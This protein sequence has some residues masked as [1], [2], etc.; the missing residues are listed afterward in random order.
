M[1]K[2]IYFYTSDGLLKKEVELNETTISGIHGMLTRCTLNNGTQ[3]S[4]YAV[5]DEKE[6][7]LKLWNWKN[8]DEEKHILIGDNEEKFEQIFQDIDI[9]HLIKVESI[10]YSN[11]RWGGRLTNIFWI[12]KE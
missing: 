12:N 2:K 10:L 1:E 8:I 5:Y 6:G 7:T 9:E 11:P 4:G 3:V